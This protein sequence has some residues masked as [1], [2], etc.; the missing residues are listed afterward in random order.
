[1]GKEG[2]CVVACGTQESTY[3]FCLDVH[4]FL[5]VNVLVIGLVN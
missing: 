4:L 2:V 3:V 5:L 1:M